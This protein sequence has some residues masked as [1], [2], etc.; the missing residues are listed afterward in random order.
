MV[1]YRDLNETPSKVS[2]FDKS[3]KGFVYRQTGTMYIFADEIGCVYSVSGWNR[4]DLYTFHTKNKLVLKFSA[5]GLPYE[6]YFICPK[7]YKPADNLDPNRCNI[8]GPLTRSKSY[9]TLKDHEED[10]K[11]NESSIGQYLLIGGSIIIILILALVAFKC[12]KLKKSK[13]ATSSKKVTSN[14]TNKPSFFSASKSSLNSIK[15]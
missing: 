3:P 13:F 5:K 1:L 15:Q 4:T 9:A 6:K 2:P 12:I 14:S 8:D 10:R 11:G 7:D